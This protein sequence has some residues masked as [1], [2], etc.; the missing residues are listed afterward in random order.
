MRYDDTK[1]RLLHDLW[2]RDERYYDLAREQVEAAAKAG[3]EYDFLK[4][5]L[6]VRGT[7]LEVG[8]G[9]G[10]N[11]G[12]VERDGL[13]FVGCDL[14]GLALS[15]ART[16]RCGGGVYSDQPAP[17]DASGNSGRSGSPAGPT[18]AAS[19]EDFAFLQADAERLPFPDRFFEAVFSVSLLE[20][21]PEPGVVV[22]EMIRVLEPGGKLVLISP[23]YG[24]PLG[25]SPCRRN[26]GAGR[27]LRRLARAHLPWNSGGGAVDRRSEGKTPSGSSNGNGHGHGNGYGAG[28]AAGATGHADRRSADSGGIGA[29]S[30]V[31]NAASRRS[32]A[33]SSPRASLD[34]DHVM[35]L[36]LEGAAYDGDLDA[37]NEPELTSLRRF[38]RARGVTIE[39]S[40]SGFEW[41][42]WLGRR[43]S[44]P[45]KAARALF[46]PLGRAGI[47]PYRDFGPLIAIA[48]YKEFRV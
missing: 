2:N 20:H 27:F 18:G 29:T 13:R 14:S 22:E 38:L 3:G 39:A 30:S 26:G 5:W 4:R 1:A 40:T 24:G 43:A 11:L 12:V 47:P 31:L 41:H 48:G 36:V 23:Q 35:P 37:V 32:L 46:E 9:E 19:R 33:A 34:W 8:C 25:A 16:T 6:P 7:V 44:L 42:T 17:A 21:L 28:A 15:R 10:S 45:Q